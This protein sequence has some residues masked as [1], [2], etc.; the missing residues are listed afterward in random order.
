MNINK[1]IGRWWT[2]AFVQGMGLSL[3]STPSHNPV[4]PPASPLKGEKPLYL[5]SH[6]EGGLWG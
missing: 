2:G 4:S 5:P 3:N 1:I 6:S